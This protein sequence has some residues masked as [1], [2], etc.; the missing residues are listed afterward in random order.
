LRISHVG[1]IKFTGD[2]MDS[3][4]QENSTDTILIVKGRFKSSS[5]NLYGLFLMIFNQFRKLETYHAIV[6]S[7]SDMYEYEPHL[8]WEKYEEIIVDRKW[9]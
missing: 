1:L 5:A 9:R 7:Y 2:N 6:S 8:S 4:I 3:G